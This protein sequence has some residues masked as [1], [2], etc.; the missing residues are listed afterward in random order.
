MAE[1]TPATPVATE[2]APAV[3]LTATPSAAP[4]APAEPTPSKGFLDAK[5]PDASTTTVQDTTKPDATKPTTE[6]KDPSRPEWLKDKYKTVEDQAKAY[7]DLEKTL[8]ERG[9]VPESYET[10]EIFEKHN[11]TWP[12]DEVRDAIQSDMKAQKFTQAQA[13]WILEKHAEAQYALMAQVGPPVDDKAEQ[14]KLIEKHGQD[15]AMKMIARVQQYAKNLAS[16]LHYRS[17]FHLADGIEALDE[18]IRSH[19]GPQVI[20]SDADVSASLADLKAEQGKLVA[21]PLYYS[22]TA[23]GRALVAKNRDLSA[24][25]V[26]LTNK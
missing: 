26:A 11:L 21:D 7:A 2:T 14:S 22:N 1:A 19:T 10:K 23:Q 6:V 20:K 24:R 15:A 12:N 13:N 3:T 9:Q 17:M 5:V 16:P 18:L 8:G 25:I 4:A